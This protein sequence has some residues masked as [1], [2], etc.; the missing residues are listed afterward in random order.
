MR[1][2]TRAVSTASLAR[3]INVTVCLS[4]VGLVVGGIL[5]SF[6]AT[7]LAVRVGHVG[8]LSEPFVLG[9]VFGAAMGF[10]LAPT[11]SWAL[12]RQVPIWRAITET[13]LGA[14]MAQASASSF[15]RCTTPVGC[16]HCFSER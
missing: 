14:M 13:A 1:R 9:A 6:V 11:A 16:L 3:I 12:M 10:V 15:R 8:R 2:A 4:A 5:G 7:L